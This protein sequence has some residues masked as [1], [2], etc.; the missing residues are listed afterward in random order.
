MLL[1]SSETDLRTHMMQMTAIKATETIDE[2]VIELAMA[3]EIVTEIENDET[4]AEI[5]HAE[6]RMVTRS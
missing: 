4:A 5:E 2:I 6:R 1:L 3:A